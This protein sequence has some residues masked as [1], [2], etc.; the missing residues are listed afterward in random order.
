[1]RLRENPVISFKIPIRS[2]SPTRVLAAVIEALRCL[3]T[4]TTLNAGLENE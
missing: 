1:M 2:I 4:S 3:A